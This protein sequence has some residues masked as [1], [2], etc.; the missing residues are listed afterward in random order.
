MMPVES[1]MRILVTG[2]RG[3]IGKNLVIHLKERVD[4]EVLTFTRK[5]SEDKLVNLVSQ[6]DVIVH[7]AGENRPDNIADFARVNIDLTHTLCEAI[8]STRRNIPLILASSIQAE[9]DNPY[10]RSKRDA[11]RVVEAF[12]NKS[13]NPVIIYRLPGVFG[14]WCKPDYNSVVATFCH[15]IAHGLPIQLN[16]AAVKLQLVYIDD[17]IDEFLHALDHPQLGL[18]WGEV[19]PKYNITLGEL[20]EQIHAFGNCRTT[21]VS[22]RVGAG[23]TRALYS[24]YVSYL[25]QEHFVYDLSQ[26][27]DER[28]IFVEMLKTPD[29]GQFSFFTINPGEARGSH[30]HHSKTEKFFVIRGMV[31]M[32][33]RHKV[34]FEIYEVTICGRKPQVV[35]SIPGWVHNITNIGKSEAIVMLWSN[36]IFDHQRTDTITS[37]V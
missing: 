26:Y 17:V 24:T 34:T 23:M 31:R 32:R 5:D 1:H 8:R 18:I 36:E 19:T 33:F 35:E 25:P 20:A 6:A 14:K 16:D 9:Q 37:E 15:N 4:T 7:L 2:A 22:E 11:E 3:F 13:T 27:S 30:Y 28:G 21:L 12:A 10:G 29:C